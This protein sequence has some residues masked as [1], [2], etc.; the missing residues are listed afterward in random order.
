M[1]LISNDDG[2]HSPHLVGLADA[3]AEVVDVLVVAP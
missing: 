1:V 3:L 2:V